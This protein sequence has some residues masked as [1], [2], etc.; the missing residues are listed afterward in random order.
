MKPIQHLMNL[1][2]GSKPVAAK[3][4]DLEEASK[5]Q[6]RITKALPKDEDTFMFI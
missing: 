5:N 4:E 1:F 3:T 2:Y 6:R